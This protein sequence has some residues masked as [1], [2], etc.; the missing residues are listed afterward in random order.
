M[1]FNPKVA[2]YSGTTRNIDYTPGSAVS[3]GDVVVVNSVLHFAQLDIAAN[4]LGALAAAD[5]VWKGNKVTGAISAGD[6]IYWDASGSPV[7]GTV[8]TGAFTKTPTASTR[9]AGYAVVAAASGDSYVYFW[10]SSS[11]TDYRIRA[12]QATSASATD[13]IVTGLNVVV[14]AV[15]TY[16]GDASDANF[17]VTATTGD[18]AG[19]P[20][21]GSF[22]LKTWK[23][24]SGTD[25]TPVATTSFSVKVNW[26]AFGY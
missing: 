8:S 10:K 5:G 19:T 9:F 12:G 2:L 18:Q 6:R 20:A 21:A 7:T 22:I 11:D 1:S 24:T 13:T 23:N 25:P 16:D 26:I 14:G 17:T 3:A 4:A 15:A